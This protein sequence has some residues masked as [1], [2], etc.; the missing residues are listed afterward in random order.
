[1]ALSTLRRWKFKPATLDGKSV[2]S[3]R[4]IKVEFEV[5]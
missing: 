2:D 3:S 1:M 5:E 4:K